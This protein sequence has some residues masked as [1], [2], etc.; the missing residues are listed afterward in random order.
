MIKSAKGQIIHYLCDSYIHDIS[1]SEKT[2]CF[3]PLF[4]HFFKSVRY[5]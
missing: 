3:K 4:T 1:I 2:I 5:G